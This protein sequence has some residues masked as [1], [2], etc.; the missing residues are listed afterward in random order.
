[1][2][3]WKLLKRFEKYLRDPRMILRTNFYHV[4]WLPFRAMAITLGH[5]VLINHDCVG[6]TLAWT[7]AHELKHVEQVEELGFFGFYYRYLSEHRRKGYRMN[8]YE[9]V[10]RAFSE[11]VME[12]EF[13]VSEIK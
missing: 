8:R 13:P 6:R 5:I 4:R 12:Q 7:V 2:V 10:A 3:T 1:M 11:F 9:I